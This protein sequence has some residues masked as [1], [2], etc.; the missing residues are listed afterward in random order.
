[1]TLAM[2]LG[3]PAPPLLSVRLKYCTGST[4][5][6]LADFDWKAVSNPSSLGSANGRPKADSVA[7]KPVHGATRNFLFFD[8]RVAAKKVTTPQEY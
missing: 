6:A 1:M 2:F 4:V 3:L 7:V 8:G 5:W